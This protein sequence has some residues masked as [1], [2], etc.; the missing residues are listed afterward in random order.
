MTILKLV[1]FIRRNHQ[2]MAGY[3]IRI[4]F[5]NCILTSLQRSATSLFCSAFLCRDEG[6]LAS[7]TIFVS[8]AINSLE[9]DAPIT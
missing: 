2:I 4:A 9:A 1:M 6:G 7:A 5:S 8:L 3:N